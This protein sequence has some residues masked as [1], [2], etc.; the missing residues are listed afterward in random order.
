M[1]GDAERAVLPKLLGSHRGSL[2]IPP[3]GG[4]SAVDHR[5]RAGARY[6]ASRV[7]NPPRT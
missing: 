4:L 1:R 6:A 7:S 5:M 3:E 2:I